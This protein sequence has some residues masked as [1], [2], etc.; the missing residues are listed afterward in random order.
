MNIQMEEMHRARY[1]GRGE[2]LPCPLQVHHLPSTF[3]HSAVQWL[4]E[5]HPFE[6]FMEASSC[7][8]W[9][10]LNSVTSLSPLAGG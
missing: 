2:E 7:R 5:S 4:S 3:M 6:D 9:S 8:A 1:G 10:V